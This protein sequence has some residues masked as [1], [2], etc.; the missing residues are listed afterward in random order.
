MKYIY[1]FWLK[2]PAAFNDDF[3]SKFI[4]IWTHIAAIVS[5]GVYHFLTNNQPLE[6]YVCTGQDPTET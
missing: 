3:W 5:S 1:I 4:I 2:N 6:F